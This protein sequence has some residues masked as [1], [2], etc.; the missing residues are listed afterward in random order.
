MKRSSRRTSSRGGGVRRTNDSPPRDRVVEAEV[1]RI[2]PGGHGLAHVDGRTVFVALAA[3]GDLVRARVERVR[4]G[5]AFASIVE[6]LRPSP[7][8]VEP[9]CEYFGRCG[10]CD[11]QQ[12]NYDAQLRAK[13]EIV[14]DCLRRI[15]RLDPPPPVEI[16]PSPQPW[17]YRSRAQWQF[18]QPRQLF[19][20]YERAS[21]NI[22]D[23][24]R[25]PVLEPP[26]EARLRSL[27]EQI[28]NDEL[29]DATGEVGAAVGD[30]GAVAAS[31]PDEGEPELI[32]RTVGGEKYL[33][34]ASGF[35]QINHALLETL[36]AEAIGDRAGEFA[37]DL[38]CGVGLFTLPLAKRFGRVVGVEA[39]APAIALA[40]RNAEAA[41]LTNVDF[42]AARVG[43]W[44]RGRESA[45]I[46]L[47]LLD[48]PRAGAGRETIDAINALAPRHVAYVSCEPSTLARD[49]RLLL[50]GRYRVESVVALDMF[51]QTHHVET[52]VHL[53]RRE[54][55]GD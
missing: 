24:A 49:L 20:Y 2:I 12:L 31:F 51:P 29:H 26:L 25:C 36:V 15:G 54:I 21:H 18:D 50:D 4:G 46:D 9:P 19:G 7:D 40:R 27:R 5:A 17:H 55:N 52:V 13:V 16:V 41:R 48:P 38:Y 6:I 8:R 3:P 32:A 43:E 39:H 23:V 47:L 53:A 30:G 11:F 14:R 22:C 10:G 33:F 28:S 37:L 34:D 35:F 42:A 45:E 1:T 44:L